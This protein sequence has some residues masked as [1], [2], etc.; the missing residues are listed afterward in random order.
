MGLPPIGPWWFIP[1][2]MQFYAIW[3][4]L[5]KLTKRFGWQGLVVLSAICFIISFF[6]NPILEHWSIN[7]AWTPIGR[8]RV[9]CLGIIAARYPI[10]INAYLAIPAFAIMILGSEYRSVAHFC[11]LAIVILTLWVYERVRIPLRSFRFLEQIGA[12]SLA[13][14]LVN[15]V[16]RVPFRSFATTPLSQ[17][18]LAVASAAVTLAI[19][20]FFHY[21]LEPVPESAAVSV[22]V[23]WRKSEPANVAAD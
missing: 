18:L 12:Y 1:F 3:L 4:L 19:S 7:L 15:G 22:R 17:L 11:S 14:F 6:A 21:L 13:I 5:R 20:A 2:I 10:R 8:M 9:L 16:V 23:G